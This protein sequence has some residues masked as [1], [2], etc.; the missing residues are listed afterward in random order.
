MTTEILSEAEKMRRVPGIYFTDT[1][2]GRIATIVGTGLGVWQVIKPYL[3]FGEN[4]NTLVDAFHWLS[5]DQLRA[6]LAYYDT[7]PGE[8]DERLQLDVDL[9][10]EKVYEMYPFTRP[11]NWPA[12]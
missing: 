9:T 11:K 12:T 2:C 3:A 7:F 5:K 4:W 6:A 10:P 1:A 8:V